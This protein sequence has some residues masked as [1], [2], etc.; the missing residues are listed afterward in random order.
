VRRTDAGALVAVIGVFALW[1]GLTRT[2][3][4]YVRPSTGTWLV[5]AGAVL[6]LFGLTLIVVGRG[7]PVE[8]D[9]EG[10]SHHAGRIGW[11]LA[12]PVAIAIAVGT[13]PLGSYAAGRQTA[14]RTLPP[15]HLDLEAYLNAGSFAG[16]APALRMLDFV[17]SSY[18]PGDRE[19]LAETPVTLTG[20]VTEDDR[21]GHH[22]RGFLLTRFMVGCC[23]A[24]AIAIRV[25]VPMTDGD[26]PEP[27]DWVQVE[28][29][30][31]LAA[32][33]PAGDNSEPPVLDARDIHDVDPPD[34]VYEYPP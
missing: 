14:D 27:D 16:Q 19:L 12:L 28:G 2:A 4:L 30:L 6:V 3:L 9:G 10:H 25:R 7:R 26:L 17:R 31:D 23:A 5:V 29:S 13:N 8:D 20:F 18:D 33:P 21:D 15:G 1:M 11:M 32:S 22:G 24:D 34:E